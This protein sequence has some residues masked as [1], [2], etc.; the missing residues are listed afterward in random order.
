VPSFD[1][2]RRPWIPVRY[3]RGLSGPPEAGLA[4]L[5]ARAGEIEDITLPVPPAASGLWRILYLIASRI[6]G[7]GNP[8]GFDDLRSW[9]RERRRVL[10]AGRFD[11]DAVA[12][13]FTACADGL[14]LFHPARPWLQ[15]T[16]LA[17]ECAKSTGINKLVIERASGNNLVWLSHHSDLA[18]Q[19]IRAAE[20]AWYLLAWLYYGPSG[21]ITP[22]TV[23]GRKEPN[24]TAGPL[25]S[26]IS[27]H[28]LG[29]NLFESIITGIPYPGGS[30]ARRP[31]ADL[32]PWEDTSASDP[33]GTPPARQGL[34]GALTGQ[35][36]HA[37]LLTPSVDGTQATDARIT[38][39]WREPHAPFEDPYLIYETPKG[40]STAFPRYARADRAIWRD[41]DALMLQETGSG[42]TR[43]PSV[44][45][46]LL[47]IEAGDVTGPLRVRAFGFVQDGQTVDRQ[48][49]T[50]LTP[51]VLS[52]RE[53][54]DASLGF[55]HSHEIGAAREA[56]ERVASDLRRALRRA[57]NALSNP[58]E[59]RGKIRADASD[60]PWVASA[61]GRYWP[62][63][64]AA[65]WHMIDH[66][67]E[68]G[69]PGN[70]FIRLALAAYD[71][72]T[73]QYSRR[74]PRA[75]RVL[76]RARGG[77]LAAWSRS[78]PLPLETADA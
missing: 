34:S 24:M 68:F 49:F 21:Q 75:A 72:V 44:F 78:E 47:D 11:Q 53:S 51:P 71:E 26:R 37:L 2:T 76:E 39:A 63:A 48:W 45:S 31:A 1:L 69:F 23:A 61:L 67:D 41:L 16:R 50:A 70:R 17:A 15:D 13:Y 59:L 20:A 56:A 38:W 25:R 12:E 64:E 27:F 28:P 55:D 74:G 29:R 9:K 14:D 40:K 3:A 60:G 66:P 52:V 5:F 6:T 33:L 4:E 54:E 36:R 8:A 42:A 57:W 43:R 22:R 73:D 77:I 10:M 58:E 7:L 46:N 32:A 35:F 18:P 19:P 30:H 62:K 65:F